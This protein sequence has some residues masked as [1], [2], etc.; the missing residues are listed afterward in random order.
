[1]SDTLPADTNRRRTPRVRSYLGAKA[2]VGETEAQTQA[3][4]IRN[5]SAHGAQVEL[6]AG[7][8]VPMIWWLIDL[9][10]GMAYMVETMWRRYPRVGLL[11]LDRIALDGE[12]TADH[13][14]LKALWMAE[15]GLSSHTSTLL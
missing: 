12:V 5:L 9:S 11:I 14:H 8:T 13:R 10:H 3:C 7:M 1:M 6:A 4:V 15:R 2:V